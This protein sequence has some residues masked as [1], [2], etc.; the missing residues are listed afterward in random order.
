MSFEQCCQSKICFNIYKNH[1]NLTYFS[2]LCLLQLFSSNK[3][4]ILQTLTIQTK[5]IA[6]IIPLGKAPWFRPLGHS[7]RHDKR[8]LSTRRSAAAASRTQWCELHC[9]AAV[10]DT[11]HSY[12]S[13]LNSDFEAV[14]MVAAAATFG[15]LTSWNAWVHNLARP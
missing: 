7:D 2:D 15:A 12:L 1:I 13:G 14:T 4:Q 9:H 6:P 10:N 11:V 3:M 5:I 8:P